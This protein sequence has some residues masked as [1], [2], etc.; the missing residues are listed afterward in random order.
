M[1]I[2]AQLLLPNVKALV[3]PANEGLSPLF[4]TASVIMRNN[5]GGIQNTT[6]SI[7]FAPAFTQAPRIALAIKRYKGKVYVIDRA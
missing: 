7:T 3:E 6:T 4:R 5:V 1:V 2:V